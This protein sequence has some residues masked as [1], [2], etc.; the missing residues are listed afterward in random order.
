ME[1]GST[2][3]HEDDY[4]QIEILPSENYSFCCKQAGLIDKFAEEHRVGAG[5]TDMYVRESNPVPLR[6]MGLTC[7]ELEEVLRPL[8]PYSDKVYTGYS[9]YCELC[10]DTHGFVFNENVSLFYAFSGDVIRDIWLQ[11]TP[12]VEEEACLAKKMLGAIG[13]LGDFIIAD[14]SWGAVEK[15]SDAVAVDNYLQE[16]YLSF[17][18]LR[19]EFEE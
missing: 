8:L 7:L 13:C 3:F 18:K 14:W 19:E 10:E 16:K 5:Y 2:Y 11:L 12:D 9:S 15:L 1:V 4:G 17:S 6:E